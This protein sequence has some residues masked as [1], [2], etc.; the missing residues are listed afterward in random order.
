LHASA[1]LGR[2]EALVEA[3]RGVIGYVHARRS[4]GFRQVEA[5]SVRNGPGEVW[6]EDDLKSS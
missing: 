1:G 3:A 4:K 6:G 5:A 2:N